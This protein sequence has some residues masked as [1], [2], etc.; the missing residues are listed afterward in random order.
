L[1]AE[2]NPEHMTSGGQN[3]EDKIFILS[4][5]EMERY[6]PADQYRQAPLTPYAKAQLPDINENCVYYKYWLR[7]PGYYPYRAM[8]V[9]ENGNIDVDGYTASRGNIALR[10]AMWLHRNIID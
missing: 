1:N 4:A 8:I 10:P 6:F 9:N 7:G 2:D 3:T 5:G